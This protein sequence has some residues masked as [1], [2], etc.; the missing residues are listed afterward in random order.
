MIFVVYGIS[1]S[2]P[3]QQA[4]EQ[5]GRPPGTNLALE[6]QAQPGPEEAGGLP[7]AEWGLPRLPAAGELARTVP[8]PPRQGKTLIE[9]NPGYGTRNIMRRSLTRENLNL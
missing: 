6:P 9:K 1:F 5:G 2:D 7:V 8:R 4:G 3:D